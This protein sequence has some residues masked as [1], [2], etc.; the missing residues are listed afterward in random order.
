MHLKK[1]GGI[2]EIYS[3]DAMPGRNERAANVTSLLDAISSDRG[4]GMG[5]I[6]DGIYTNGLQ[7]S[8]A[9]GI[10]ER[11]VAKAEPEFHAGDIIEGIVTTV[12]EQISINFSGK[13]FH[14]PKE[15]VQNAKE[16]EKR[17]YKIMEAS[18]ASFVLKE[19][20]K[21]KAEGGQGKM[22]FTTVDTGMQMIAQNFG[23][24]PGQ[25][26]EEDRLG[27]ISDRATEEDCKELEEEGMTLEKYSLERLE[28]LLER[29]KAQT[30]LKQAGI[31][32][33]LEDKQ[34]RREAVAK[35][36]KKNA[37]REMSREGISE[38]IAERLTA[39]NLPV[40][41][42]NVSRIAD[43]VKMAGEAQ[44]M[45]EASFSYLIG[46]GLEPTIENCYKAAHA[47]E[48]RKVPVSDGLMTQLEPQIN[49]VLQQAGQLVGAVTEDGSGNPDV[50]RR[51][52]EANVQPEAP[53]VEDARWLL[54]RELPLTAENLTYKKELERL[55]ADLGD[56]RLGDE[57][58]LTGTVE[59]MYR[60][61]EPKQT[62]LSV[63]RRKEELRLQM[64]EEA[65][66]TMLKL[67]VE[68]DIDAI[69]ER[70]EG[71]KQQEQEYFRQ[72]LTAE[73]SETTEAAVLFEQTLAAA[74]KVRNADVSL[75]AKSFE[76]RTV[77]TLQSLAELAT[78]SHAVSMTDNAEQAV[79]VVA[80]ERRL[81]TV[82]ADAYEP[83]MT[84][85]R[86]DMGDSIQKAFR[87]V[88]SQLEALG[89]EL[90][91]AN[92]RAVRILGY[93]SIPL[94]QENINE[95]KFYDA[96]VRGLAEQL[97]PQV[98]VELI[99]RGINPLEGSLQQVSEAAQNI[100]RE[101]G[102]SAEERFS[103]YL[104]KLDRKQELTAEERD[105]YIGIYRMLYQIEKTDGAAI[106]A[107]VKSGREL[108]LSNLL[109]E[110][111]GLRRRG[112]DVSVDDAFGE[113]E[114][115]R[116]G[117]YINDQ[118]AAAYHNRQ[119]DKA[120]EQLTPDR[121]QQL[122]ERGEEI[123]GLTPERLAEA[124]A[125]LPEGETD[126]R[127]RSERL[128]H[129]RE[130]ASDSSSERRFLERFG[131]E[132]S[133]EQIQAAKQLLQGE[134]SYRKL[135][136]IAGDAGNT[137]AGAEDSTEAVLTEAGTLADG[138]SAS[139]EELATAM[140]SRENMAAL[141]ERLQGRATELMEALYT[142]ADLD[143]EQA[144][145]LR[146]LLTVQNLK[147]QL[148]QK[149]CF[150]I[151]I[152]DEKGITGMRLT[153]IHGSGQTGRFRILLQQAVEESDMD[154]AAVRVDGNY[155]SGKLELLLTAPDR[156][157][158]DCLKAE[159]DSLQKR[160]TQAGIVC[161]SIFCS[162]ARTGADAMLPPQSD[163]AWQTEE[164]QDEESV[165]TS[166]LYT[167]AKETV[168]HIQRIISNY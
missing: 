55:T 75:L 82:A 78:A 125:E 98:T 32:G 126:R 140:E 48:G 36:A 147:Q 66:D 1:T 23:T 34:S 57:A 111:R 21:A 84:A 160:L 86:R 35:T 73:G 20:G 63:L 8:L 28:R 137:V 157:L 134:N 52:R 114:T 99:R 153:V 139:E 163:T 46:N 26:A 47:G 91:V 30:A 59:N 94:T 110:S 152:A 13:E 119:L 49:E 109:T 2:A 113:A 105:T 107:L 88:D 67:G 143:A 45:T 136:R 27:S 117:Q 33:Q 90:T 92:Q 151:P 106:G 71:L 138:L 116:E 19:I 132:N 146:E 39:A 145:A 53:G 89:M 54:E 25:Q 129:L 15:A 108:T 58:M 14:F 83:L 168:L 131:L 115:V 85:P 68:A 150:E 6:M 166:V 38:L 120:M 130:L 44:Y 128:E 144:G 97:Q 100:S 76:T 162:V 123:A 141:T 18:G 40:T 80:A 7:S 72:M 41:E 50:A 61:V 11:E 17:T 22:L 70:I 95:M 156:A 56:G 135:L 62:N 77:Q 103:E 142:A 93:N 16:G 12:S 9:N 96:Q 87:N 31:E 43:A 158:S 42:N 159:S 148:A 112:M 4:I 104:V 165:T 121:L 74:D 65:A 79:N 133:L 5:N 164:A 10:R 154:E 167:A 29:M 69:K 149:E 101:L 118:I 37:I 127:Y 155:R 64:T 124:T 60:G 122:M 161:D 102:I 24:L 81:Q 51:S 3:V